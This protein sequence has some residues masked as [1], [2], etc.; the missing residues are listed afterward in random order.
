[1]LRLAAA[2]TFAFMALLSVFL[3]GSQPEMLC[4]AAQGASPLSGMALMCLLM[5]AFRSC[6]LA[7]AGLPPTKRRPSVLI[8]RSS[9]RRALFAL[10]ALCGEGRP[11]RPASRPT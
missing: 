6:A 7:E 4:S 3:G 8:Q 2:P 9:G 1:M 5:S 11:L 10:N